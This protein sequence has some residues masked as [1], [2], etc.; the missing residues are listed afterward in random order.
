MVKGIPD[1]GVPA[2]RPLA[3][4]AAR[5]TPMRMLHYFAI[6]MCAVVPALLATA[7]LGLLGKADLH[8]SVGLVAAIFAVG[9]HT[10][11]IL[12]MIVTGRVLREAIKA[13][14]LG[15]EFLKELNEF[16]ARKEAYPAAVFSSVALV[17]AG[18]LGY[19][20]PSL[21]LSPILHMLA[22][23]AALALNLWAMPVEFRALRDNRDLM[24]RAAQA[25]DRID[26]EL[27]EKGELPEEEPLTPS[28]IARGAMIVAISAW[29]PWAYWAVVEKRGNFAEAS[30]HPYLEVS[31]LSLGVW[32]LARRAASEPETT[33]SQQAS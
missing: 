11:V 3:H 28:A 19:G 32:I 17:G 27:E 33:G 5:D 26:R 20:A 7:I 23:T 29:M 9:L 8:L 4:N 24:D 16:F 1:T 2:D 15:Q 21:G 25:L 14:D 30:V 13:R 6:A 22:G 10:L 12:F 18:V 31:L